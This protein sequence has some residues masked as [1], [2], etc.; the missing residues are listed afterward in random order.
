MA[1]PVPR[2]ALVCALA[3]CSLT[4]CSAEQDTEGMN[5]TGDYSSHQ[6]LSVVG[7]PSTGSLGIAQEV[8][9]RIA[10][11]DVDRLA[12]LVSDKQ[13]EDIPEKTAENWVAAFRKGAGG[14]VTA[15]FYDEGSYRQTVVLYLHETGQIKE[16][17]VRAVM[18]DGKEVWRVGMA[19]PGPAEATAVEPWIPKTPGE[20]GSKV[21]R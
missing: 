16:L 20:L 15:E 14:K 6:P 12:S 1:V 11:G 7:Y 2:A 8:V 17:Y 10:D 4:A 19:E 13:G 21:V 3:L 18:L 5:Y 9:W